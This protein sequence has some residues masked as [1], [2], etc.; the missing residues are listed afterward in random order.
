MN[1][2]DGGVRTVRTPILQIAYEECGDP[3]APAVILLHGFPDDVRAWD[4]VAGPVAKAGHRVLVPYL[5]GFGPTRFLSDGEPR[6]GQQAALAQDLLAFMDAL[7][8]RAA[9]I[10][11]YDWGGRAACIVTILAP[12]RVSGLV[13]VGGYNVQNTTAPSPPAPPVEER[14]YWYQ[15]YLN[16]E[17]G[18]LGLAE[19]RRELCRLLWEEWSPLWRLADP[20][21]E[22]T[23]ASFDNPD[24][25]SVVVHSYRHRHGLAPGLP[26]LMNVERRLAK[27][28]PIEVPSI[29][30][31]GG[32]DGVLP[33]YR[34]EAHLELFPAGTPR[35]VVPGA[36]HF[37]PRERPDVLVDALLKLSA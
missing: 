2:P 29:V 22:R 8:V 15:W 37:L 23:A 21:F 3:R 12:E 31:H 30:L 4:E 11:G 10:A 24:F 18:R 26:C 9:T 7:E 13:T 36:G 5:R 17:R 14:A 28:P 32:V 27:R 25:V 6:S 35:V 20:S 16:T 34:S 19:N 33:A 1:E